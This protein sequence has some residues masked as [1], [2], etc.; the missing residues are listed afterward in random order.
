MSK[1]TLGD[2]L[3]EEHLVSLKMVRQG[4]LPTLIGEN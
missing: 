1:V 4:S 3:H 2:V